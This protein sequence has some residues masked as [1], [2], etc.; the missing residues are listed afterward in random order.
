MLCA[1][2]DFRE[3][4]SMGRSTLDTMQTTATAP[5]H[6][7]RM[8]SPIGRIEIIGNGEDR[9]RRDIRTVSERLFRLMRRHGDLF[10]GKRPSRK[11]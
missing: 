10:A 4:T 8:A 7:R 9:H 1:M 3:S 2:S 5:E 6:L 11:A